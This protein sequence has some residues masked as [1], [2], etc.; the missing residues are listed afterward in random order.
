MNYG[1]VGFVWRIVCQFIHFH[2]AI[3]IIV[4]PSMDFVGRLGLSAQ[5]SIHPINQSS[6]TGIL[7]YRIQKKRRRRKDG[8]VL[9]NYFIHLIR[10]LPWIT[11]KDHVGSAGKIGIA[12]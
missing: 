12:V 1:V 2:S 3:I 9:T 7:W 11:T 8:E 6:I 5:S 10:T 4:F